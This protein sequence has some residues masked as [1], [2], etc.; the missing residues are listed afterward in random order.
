MT[1]DFT[2]FQQYFSHIRTMRGDNE[3]LCA[4]GL[5]LTVKKISP[6]AGLDTAGSVGQR[7]T[8]WGTGGSSK[9][10]YDRDA[11]S[12]CIFMQ[13]KFRVLCLRKV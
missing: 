11:P 10:K 13:N 5:C 8:P 4:I 2:S 1:S 12:E 6:R 9:H 3:G 7:L